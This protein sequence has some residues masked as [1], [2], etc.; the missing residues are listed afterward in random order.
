MIVTLSRQYAAGSSLVAPRVA[1]ELGWRVFDNEMVQLVA[2]RA[3][4]PPEEVARREERVPAFIDR[5]ARAAALAMPDLITPPSSPVEEL[6][7]ER[8]VKI[9]RSLVSELA[10]EGR[11]VLVG[12]AAAAAL[13]HES[14]VLRV[15]LIA[16]REARLRAC[17]E[18]LGVAP[19]AAAARLDEIDHNRAAYH[20]EFYQRDW[21]DPTL[22]HMLLN[23]DAL[24]HDRVAD[25][26]VSAVHAYAG[27]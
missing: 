13:A 11:L 24:G 17:A 25:L 5:F 22:Y 26:I 6:T 21:A 19:N 4:L 9:T 23:T 14:D 2:E 10:S 16:P 12:R 15:R 20:R 27:A 7:E 18:R 1:S 8:L 3:G